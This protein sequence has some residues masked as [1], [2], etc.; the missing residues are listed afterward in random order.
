[1]L[2]TVH[3]RN[4]SDCLLPLYLCPAKVNL[5]L[6]VASPDEQGMHPNCSWME[7]VN[8]FDDLIVDPLPQ[9]DAS[10]FKVD[11]AED[12]PRRSVIDWPVENDLVFKAHQLMESHVEM[13]CDL[14]AQ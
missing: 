2:V 12:A 13:F 9:G 5:V 8:L 4:E 3:L 10:V 1:M 11:W 7:Q 6:S 14:G